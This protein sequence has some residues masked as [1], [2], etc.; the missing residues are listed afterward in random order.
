M[1]PRCAN[2]SFVDFFA[3]VDAHDDKI[4]NRSLAVSNARPEGEHEH[5]HEH[6]T[7]IKSSATSNASVC[8]A[9]ARPCTGISLRRAGIVLADASQ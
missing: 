2:D 8:C 7:T 5:E 4:P 9:L 1:G 6:T 3:D